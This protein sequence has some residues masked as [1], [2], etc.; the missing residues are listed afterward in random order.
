MTTKIVSEILGW[1]GS[2]VIFSGGPAD[3][4]EHIL[5]QMHAIRDGGGFG[6]IIGR[7]SFQRSKENAL[8]LLDQIMTIY[9]AAKR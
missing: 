7:N 5:E 2:I 8:K 6:S 9:G 3:S 4:D 1:Y